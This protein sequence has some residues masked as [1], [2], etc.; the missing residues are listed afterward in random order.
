MI[1]ITPDAAKQI[2]KSFPEGDDKSVL[3]IAVKEKPDGGF[4]YLMGL[5]DAKS[6]DAQA[7]SNDVRIAFASEHIPLLQ[8]MEVDY[9]E[10]N[11]GEFNFIF[12]NPNDPTHKTDEK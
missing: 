7:V 4:H 2:L 9:V 10:L 3:R 11:P 6:E 5:D 8:G 1:T 12:K